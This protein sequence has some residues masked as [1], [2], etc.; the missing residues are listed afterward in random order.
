MRAEHASTPTEGHRKIYTKKYI[1]NQWTMRLAGSGQNRT[2]DTYQ[3]TTTSV[4]RRDHMG[5]SLDTSGDG[6]RGERPIRTRRIWDRLGNRNEPKMLNTSRH[7]SA[8]YDHDIT[9][10]TQ[11]KKGEHN[12]LIRTEHIRERLGDSRSQNEGTSAQ[13]RNTH[14]D[15]GFRHRNHTHG[16]EQIQHAR[17]PY[18]NDENTDRQSDQISYGPT[19]HQLDP[20]KYPTEVAEQTESFLANLI[21]NLQPILREHLHMIKGHNVHLTEPKEEI[22]T[23]PGYQGTRIQQHPMPRRPDIGQERSG[24]EDI[25]GRYIKEEKNSGMQAVFNHQNTYGQQ[26]P[27]SNQGVVIKKEAGNTT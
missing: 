18:T 13:E 22:W 23:T 7:T 4:P 1:E 27:T 12:R 20:N 9:Q 3:L 24:E 6:V 8:N 5:D 26:Y 2:P 11:T 21:T 19:S 25:E 14:Q 16:E 17:R 10:D 15:G